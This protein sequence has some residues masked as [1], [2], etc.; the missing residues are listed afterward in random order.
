MSTRLQV[1]ETKPSTPTFSFT[2]APAGVLQR[3]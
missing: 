3:R 2:P 1:Q